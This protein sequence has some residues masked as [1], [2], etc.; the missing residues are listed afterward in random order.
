METVFY[1]RTLINT[2]KKKFHRNTKAPVFEVSKG[3]D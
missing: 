2:L 1:K 3:K